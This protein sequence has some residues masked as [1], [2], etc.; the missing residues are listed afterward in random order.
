MVF[1]TE[2]GRCA[3]YAHWL[4]IKRQLWLI[5]S[6]FTVDLKNLCIN[7]KLMYDTIWKHV[8]SS[9]MLSHVNA[10]ILLMKIVNVGEWTCKKLIFA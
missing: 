3:G 8:V 10:I 1:V 6:F 2:S 9:F 7:Y 4:S 5:S